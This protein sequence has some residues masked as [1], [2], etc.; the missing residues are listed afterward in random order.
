MRIRPI[1]AIVLGGAILSACGV[2]PSVAPSSSA[3]A[4]TT[5]ASAAA[6]PAASAASAAPSSAA[7]D[8]QHASAGPFS[9]DVPAGW[10]TRVG[11]LNPGG[12]EPL[13]YLS[14]TELPTDC[15]PSGQLIACG[16]WPN[17]Q[18]PA[19]G[20]VV[21]VRGYYRPGSVPPSGGLSIVVG[22]QQAR[23]LTSPADA[24]CQAIGGTQLVRIIFPTIV[25]ANGW[26]SIDACLAGPDLG[27]ATATFDA[28]LASLT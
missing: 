2:T 8:V 5:A 26:L 4:A 28:I 6:S 10:Q 1:T 17:M 12:D 19:D 27:P 3:A 24:Q 15:L 13:L 20:V 25:G 23:R 14:P 16:M 18:L 21:A 7:S 22:G 9:L 11:S